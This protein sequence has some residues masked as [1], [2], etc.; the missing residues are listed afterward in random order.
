MRN[1]MHESSKHFCFGCDLMQKLHR[2]KW[3]I[4]TVGYS[5]IFDILLKVYLHVYFCERFET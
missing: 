4:G 2:A 1:G 5:I 3:M